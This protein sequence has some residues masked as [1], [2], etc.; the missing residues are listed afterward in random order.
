MKQDGGMKTESWDFYS[1][2]QW[3]CRCNVRNGKKAASVAKDCLQLCADPPL[4]AG[5]DLLSLFMREPRDVLACDLHN[6]PT[7]QLAL[8]SL[9]PCSGKLLL[10]LAFS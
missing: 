9:A 7:D 3:F 5:V 10:S 4:Q 8:A 6:L 1:T 2:W